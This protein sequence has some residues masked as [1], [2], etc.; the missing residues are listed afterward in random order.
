MEKG[1][2]TF[3]IPFLMERMSPPATGLTGPLDATYLSVA[4]QVEVGDDDAWEV[5]ENLELNVLR[6][7]DVVECRPERR[8]AQSVRRNRPSE[9]LVV[10]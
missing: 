7:L 5:V 6:E 1:F 4:R 9:F 10:Q 3:R 8:N 2:N